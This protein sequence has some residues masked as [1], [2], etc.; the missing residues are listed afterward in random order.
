MSAGDL[1]YFLSFRKPVNTPLS[2]VSFPY[3]KF[4]P[5]NAYFMLK[6]TGES[7]T[8]YGVEYSF[9]LSSWVWLAYVRVNDNGV[10][11]S[12]LL[13]RRGEKAFFRLQPES[14]GGGGMNST[15]KFF[16]QPRLMQKNR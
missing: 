5:K 13:N 11:V 1:V 9:D 7:N 6:I 4:M 3:L 2:D 12:S 8:V 14:K 15:I 10:W 16:N